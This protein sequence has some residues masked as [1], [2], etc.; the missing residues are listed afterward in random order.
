MSQ[1]KFFFRFRYLHKFG[2]KM[3]METRK[4]KNTSN[5]LLKNIAE[6]KNFSDKVLS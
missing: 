3:I 5:D 2:N 1:K 4:M 6:K